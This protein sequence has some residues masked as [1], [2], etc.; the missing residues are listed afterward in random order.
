[1]EKQKYIRVGKVVKTHGVKGELKIKFDPELLGLIT[2]LN[3]LFFNIEKKYMPYFTNRL[4]L[5]ENGEAIAGLEELKSKE[6]AQEFTGHLIFIEEK[7][8]D[9]SYVDLDYNFLIGFNAKD[10]Q[11]N[12]I[13]VIDDIFNMPA[14]KLARIMRDGKEVLIPLHKSFIVSVNRTKKEICFDLPDG[15]F[16]L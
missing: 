15:L 1:M 3:P 7:N 8:I 14:N 4:S 2:S 12:S 13:G 10:K 9:P 11:K 16:D 6:A 5:R